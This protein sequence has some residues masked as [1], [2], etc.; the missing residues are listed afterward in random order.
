MSV[1][2]GHQERIK[3]MVKQFG[4]TIIVHKNF[5]TQE[6]TSFEARGFNETDGRSSKQVIFQFDEQL[7]IPV[8]SV[9]QVKGS[10]DYWKVTDTEDVILD[11]VFVSFDVRV[12]KIN[13]VGEPTRPAPSLGTTFNLQGTHARV[14]IDSN[15]NSVNISNQNTENVFADMR[16]VI[17]TQIQ[18]EQEKT[19]ILSKLDEL[20]KSV[21]KKEFTQKYKDFIGT[22]ADHISLI[23]TFIPYLTKMLG[24]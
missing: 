11:D 14:N 12:E 17:Q 10:R 23:V 19:K 2:R 9:L 16:Q 18:N 1:G 13:I 6:A 5:N 24:G 15:D 22:V 7:D 4:K 8:G 20:E 3:I 21:G